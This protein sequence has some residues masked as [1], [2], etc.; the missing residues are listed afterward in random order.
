MGANIGTTVTGILASLATGSPAAVAVAFAHTLFNVFGCIL[1]WPMRRF[2]LFLAETFSRL[3][4]Q[5]R[6]VPI[7]YILVVFFLLPL[8][9]YLLR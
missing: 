5:R 6:W 3:S 9:V 1:I 7:V 2:P 8:G 4:A